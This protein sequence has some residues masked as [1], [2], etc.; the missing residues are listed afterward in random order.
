M[1]SVSTL[2][3]EHGL[4]Y[5][6]SNGLHQ[7][8]IDLDTGVALL[9]FGYD[10]ANNLVSITDRF[11]N[12]TVIQRDQYGVPTAIISP[13]GLKTSLYIDAYNH[14]TRVTNPDGSDYAFEYTQDGLLTA[15]T[16]P[17]GHLYTHT[18]D[19]TGRVVRVAD[20]E[21]GLWQYTGGAD[22]NGNAFASVITA[23]GDQTSHNDVTGPS[24]A[25]Y[26]TTYPDGSQS[27][28]FVAGN[29]LSASDSLPCGMTRALTHD[30]DKT[31][32]ER[33]LKQETITT[34]YGLTRTTDFS[35]DY[36]DTDNDGV[37][38]LISRTTAV[39]GKAV[40]TENDVLHATKTITSPE[41]RVLTLKYDP[42]TLV[43]TSLEAAGL[44]P[45]SYG[46]DSRGR[47]TRIT[48]DSRETAFSY[49]QY[50]FLE[51]VT[52]AGSLTTFYT[53]D[54][55]GRTTGITR[56]DGSTVRFSYDKNGNMTAL[57][58]P[59]GVLHS[60]TYNGVDR[61][62]SYQ[63]PI[64]GTYAYEYDRD[65]RLARV[66][67]P[68]GFQI[69]NTYV[70]GHL[71]RTTTPE[72]NIDYTYLCGAKPGMI[73]R[74]GEAVSYSWDGDLVTTESITGTVN[75]TLDYAW[76]N[77]FLL[78]SF[79]Y[80]GATENLSYDTDGLL[81]G[82]GPFTIS[83]NPD[84]GLAEKVSDSA[85]SLTRAFNGHGEIS[86]ESFTVNGSIT[87]SWSVVRDNSGRITR[88]TETV[89][90][91]TTVYDYTYDSLG[92]LL[93]VSRDN[94][95]V[96]SYQ[97]GANGARTFEMNAAR[98]ITGRT[99]AYSAE[100]HLLSAGNTSWQW[101]VDGFLVSRSESGLTTGYTYS[102]RGELLKV[103]LPDG[104]V[105]E[106]R[107]DPLGRRIARLVNGAI[108]EKYLWSGFTKLLAVYD[109]SDNL[110][111]R[112]RYADGR[113]PVSMS[114]GYGATFH[115]FYDQV[116]SLRAVTDSGGNVVKEIVYDA[117]GN[118]LSDS[119]PAFEMPFGFA[120]GLY[121]RDTG[122]IHF[123]H[124]DYAP[125]I[126]RWIAKDPIFFDGGD[127]DLYGYVQNNP[128]NYVDPTGQFLV[129]GT[130]LVGYV[131]GPAIVAAGTAAAYRLGPYLPAIGEFLEGFVMP[132]PPP[133][134]P[135]GYAGSATR[136]AIDEA[137]DRIS[138]W[139][140]D[141]P[142]DNCSK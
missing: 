41:G 103:A 29:G 56:P 8:T 114:D 118:V 95:T 18:Y 31:R 82:A 87:G 81:T 134:S 86:A 52:T 133:P 113:M 92:R 54:Q 122:L 13:D 51:S 104:T 63:A 44:F 119:N 131:Y 32:Q 132:G 78:S 48:A 128:V 25:I 85:F 116:G 20:Q 72:G 127:F 117:Y 88:K 66:T 19:A 27:T 3:T 126:G 110:L 50:G 6:I 94:V 108:V 106:Y 64:S 62:S 11:G 100:D 58:N 34:P 45:H 138:D 57:L 39:N 102:S 17:N 10:A 7:K 43:T 76:N 69:T 142:V 53:H 101:D 15:K 125:E 14:L 60:F 38:D 137:I 93:S 124:R 35:R 80:A 26:L 16:D 28:S 12:Q 130:V 42:A 77:D 105:I 49:D 70:N 112:F 97:Y 135:A 1:N 46:Y 21:G 40:T 91:V 89:D 5:V 139:V 37:P 121:D 111:L 84:N 79:T 4:G 22:A 36:T 30:F 61:K 115:L 23:E 59:A 73:S 120:G 136:Y 55:L 129:S 68:S 98:G 47:L 141:A 109:G 71:A 75:Q 90:G 2:F 107:Y 67:F 99:Y 83:R 33:F 24:G 96:E 140:Q 123:G 74:G 65:R 9:Q